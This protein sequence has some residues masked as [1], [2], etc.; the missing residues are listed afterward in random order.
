MELE[1]SE[2]IPTILTE[3]II[4]ALYENE[5]RDIWTSSQL[6]PV[7]TDDSF[8]LRR[9]NEIIM[10]IDRSET[11]FEYTLVLVGDRWRKRDL[12]L[13]KKYFG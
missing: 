9:T 4:G 3:K 8:V 6:N 2:T 5:K 7:Y 1:V 13:F 12:R 10:N 11:D